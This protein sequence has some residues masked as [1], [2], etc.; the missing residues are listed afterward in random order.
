MTEF[1]QQ[2]LEDLAALKSE[3]RALLGN[4]QP[5]RLRQIEDRVAQHEKLVQRFAGLGAVVGGL[6]TAIHVGI[7]IYKNRS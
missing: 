4:G 7:D 5:G 2:V 6:L 1:E 3:M